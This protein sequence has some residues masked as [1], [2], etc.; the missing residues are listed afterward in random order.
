M[1]WLHIAMNAEGLSRM[2]TRVQKSI[3]YRLRHVQFVEK[4]PA[5]VLDEALGILDACLCGPH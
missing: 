3:D 2:V 4:A 1:S 5:S